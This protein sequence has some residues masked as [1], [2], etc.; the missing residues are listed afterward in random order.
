MYCKVYKLYLDFINQS[1]VLKK[2]T[3][4]VNTLDHKS[5]DYIIHSISSVH[6]KLPGHQKIQATG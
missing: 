3:G 6:I 1:S 2:C 4:L 5:N